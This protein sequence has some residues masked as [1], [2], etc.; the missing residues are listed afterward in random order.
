MQVVGTAHGH[1]HPPPVQS[2]KIHRSIP[3]GSTAVF[4]LI[5][6]A[7]VM[8][9]LGSQIPRRFTSVLRLAFLT[10]QRP[11][12]F[13]S[14]PRAD[15]YPRGTPSRLSSRGERGASA[16]HRRRRR[17]PDPP[18][19]PPR[20]TGAAPSREGA[21]HPT[22]A[23]RADTRRARDRGR[24]PCGWRWT[25][26][27]TATAARAAA[28]TSTNSAKTCVPRLRASERPRDHHRST[29]ASPFPPECAK[30]ATEISLSCVLIEIAWGKTRLGSSPPTS[31]RTD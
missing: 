22:A 12:V 2:P 24:P 31:N 20:P 19:P 8:S 25:T 4:S 21:G 10:H 17:A 11:L 27:T 14:F 28:A 29:R 6:G 3:Q 18:L 5:H 23:S 1:P 7:L 16:D 9:R 13:I 26:T 30:L 15:R